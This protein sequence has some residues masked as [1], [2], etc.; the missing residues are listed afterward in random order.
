MFW[1]RVY[2]KLTVISDP[3]HENVSLLQNPALY[4]LDIVFSSG[5]GGVLPHNNGLSFLVHVFFGSSCGSGAP[6]VALASVA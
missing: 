3:I 1:V 6:V 5:I 2:A 4:S